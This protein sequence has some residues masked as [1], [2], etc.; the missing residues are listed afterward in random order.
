MQAA[1]LRPSRS[2]KDEV[3]LKLTSTHQRQA[4]TVRGT[5]QPTPT[6]CALVWDP[7]SQSFTLD[8]IDTEIRFDAQQQQQQQQQQQPQPDSASSG[9]TS[10]DEVLEALIRESGEPNLDNP[11]DWRHQLRH[12]QRT[13]SPASSDTSPPPPTLRIKTHARRQASMP[14]DL[15]SATPVIEIGGVAAEDEADDEQQPGDDPY[16][17]VDHGLDEWASGGGLEIVMDGA[18]EDERR[19]R[20]RLWRDPPK[21]VPISLR[22]A[23]NS[24][25]PAALKAEQEE[26]NGKENGGSNEDVDE[27][28]LGTPM[29]GQK[30]QDGAEAGVSVG[31]DDMAADF[32]DMLEGNG[33]NEEEEQ[34]EVSLVAH[35]PDEESS[36]ESEEE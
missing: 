29:Q 10:E 3:D 18:K 22:T 19:G 35:L 11:F 31:A 7:S 30:S 6:R 5:Q 27:M 23:A 13:P 4:A 34:E 25:S 1:S 32:E 24:R 15:R 12:Q 33:A 17:H 28:R 20:A 26:L 36:S 16:D 9:H 14:P 21:G 2:T 8:R